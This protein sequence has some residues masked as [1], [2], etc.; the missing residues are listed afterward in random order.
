VGYINFKNNAQLQNFENVSKYWMN[1]DTLNYVS[2]NNLAGTLSQVFY[3]DPNASHV[4]DKFRVYLPTAFSVQADFRIY[5]NWY[6]GAVF[7]HP[8]RLGKAFIRR[9]AQIAL[10]P[11]YETH[12]VEFSLPVSLYDYHHLRLGASFR[13]HFLTFGSDDLL[14]LF[15][16]NDFTGIDFYLAIKLNFRKGYCWRNRNVACENDEYGIR[17]TR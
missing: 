13:Y 17:K 8:V 4:A 5:R 11:R 15:G 3:G 6:A 1:I 10:I 16:V 14:G 9:P 12:D 7:M 2:V